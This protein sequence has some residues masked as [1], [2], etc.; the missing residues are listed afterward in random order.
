MAKGI[1]LRCHMPAAS[2]GHYASLSFVV[3]GRGQRA[4]DRSQGKE[5]RDFSVGA[6]FSRDLATSTI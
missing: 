3:I 1:A 5:E 2:L 4:A 6:A